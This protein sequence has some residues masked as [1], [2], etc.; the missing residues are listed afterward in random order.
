MWRT[1]TEIRSRRRPKADYEKR[2]TIGKPSESAED[3]KLL[4][5]TTETDSV[6]EGWHSASV[7][8]YIDDLL[9]LQT[10]VYCR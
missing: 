1:T 5:I 7:R 3:E 6:W 10:F 8:F 4:L 2:L 9:L